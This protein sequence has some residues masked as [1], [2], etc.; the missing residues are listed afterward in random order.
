VTQFTI[1]TALIAGTIIILKQTQYMK[2]YNLGFN[3]EEVVVLKVKDFSTFRNNTTVKNI[4]TNN[5]NIID[6]SFSTNIPG[7]ELRSMIA[8]LP[9]G[10][11]ENETIMCRNIAID[12]D[13]F[14]TYDVKV[15]TGR[16]FQQELSTDSTDAYVINETAAKVFGKGDDIVGTRVR[17]ISRETNGAIVIGIIEDFHHESLKQEVAPMVFSTLRQGG[18]YLSLKL[19]STNIANTLSFI[20]EEWADIEP[21]RTVD[22][23][24]LDEYFDQLYKSEE[25]LSDIFIAFSFMGI[26]IACLGLLGLVSFATLQRT[27]EIGIR[28]TMG[29][30]VWKI[31]LLL[32]K[33]F[34]ALVIVSN[35]IAIPIAWLGIRSWLENFPIRTNI[36]IETFFISAIIGFV[37]TIITITY[38]VLIAASANPVNSLRAE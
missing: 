25:R 33:E 9:E 31:Y 19:R 38:R 5:P 4:F 34:L 29:A 32:S 12:F 1:A 18:P 28:K 23:Y 8:Y 24:F 11:D 35:I 26:L 16:L 30:S 22:Y 36:T 3:Q 27:K 14:K 13:Y 2:E 21:G 10:R 7:R 17:N 6:A 15:K 20:Q 37:I